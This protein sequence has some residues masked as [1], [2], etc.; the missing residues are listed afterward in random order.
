MYLLFV[1]PHFSSLSFVLDLIFL[2]T[3]LLYHVFHHLRI[4]FLPK[5]FKNFCGQFFLMKFCLCFFELSLLRCFIS[6][7][8]HLCVVLIPCLF[9]VLLIISASWYYF[10][11]FSFINLLFGTLK[12][13]VVLFLDKSFKTYHKFSFYHF[14]KNHVFLEFHHFVLFYFFMHDLQKHVLFF[15]CFQSLFWKISCFFC[16]SPFVS[17]QKKNTS[18]KKV[19]LFI[20]LFFTFSSSF[21]LSF[22]SYLHVYFPCCSSS[23]SPRFFSFFS[24]PFFSF[25]VSLSLCLPLA[26]IIYSLSLSLMFLLFIPSKK[27]P[28]FN[29]L[30]KKLF[31]LFIPS[32]KTVFVLSPLLSRTFFLICFFQSCSFEQEKL[33]LFFFWQKNNLFNPSKNFS[34]I[35]SFDVFFFKKKKSFIVFRFFF[36]LKSLFWK[37]CFFEFRTKNAQNGICNQQCLS[38]SHFLIIFSCWEKY[39]SLQLS[40]KNEFYHLLLVSVIVRKFWEKSFEKIVFLKKTKLLLSPLDFAPS[41]FFE[42]KNSFLFFNCP[43]NFLRLCFSLFSFSVFF[44]WCLSYFLNLSKQ[45]SS[46]KNLLREIKSFF[47]KKI[48]LFLEEGTYFDPKSVQ[49]LTFEFSSKKN[50]SLKKEK[51]LFQDSHALRIACAIAACRDGWA[52]QVYVHSVVIDLGRGTSVAS[53]RLSP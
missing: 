16:R 12:Q 29:F 23:Y 37:I 21:I 38:R 10:S 39:P 41:F 1:W 53:S 5:I 46:K 43:F 27:S 34:E 11:W 30:W 9:H 45:K 31:D 42:S 47:Q 17:V 7:V 2:F 4:C 48:Q 35:L 13:I 28:L 26:M 36:F 51:N 44:F 15:L 22:V 40:E 32:C 50:I 19:T 14:G 52:S 6:C 8:F 18:K 20:F 33:T 24:L 49:K 3:L 25:H